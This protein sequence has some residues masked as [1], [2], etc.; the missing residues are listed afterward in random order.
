MTGNEDTRCPECGA[1]REPDGSPSCD[2]TARAAAALRE[3]RTAEA[4]AAEDFDPLRIRPY[5]ADIVRDAPTGPP[6]PPGP[7]HPPAPTAV[8]ETGAPGAPGTPGAPDTPGAAD[9]GEPRPPR[10]S[11]RTVPLL[12]AGT[13]IALIAVA[14]FALSA[15]HDPAPDR[16][17][18]EVRPGIPDAVTP[19]PASA[20]APPPA[21]RPPA[22]SPSGPPSAPADPAPSPG[23]A[24]PTPSPTPSGSA[25]GSASPSPSGTTSGSP[26]PTPAAVPVLRRGDTGPQVTELQQRLRRLNLYGDRIDGVFTRPVE[27]AVRNYQ[28]ARGITTEP[29]GEYGPTTRAALQSETPTP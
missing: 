16:A 2:C 15:Y 17:A 13:G 10:R 1:P 4:A 12:A 14:G 24:S 3:T 25:S 11:R 6:G 27:D 21:P 9:A 8:A 22:P 7:P 18:P 26:R 5:V 20:S 28:L 29:L 23:S 19:G